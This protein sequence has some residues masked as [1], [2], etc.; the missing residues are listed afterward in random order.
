MKEREKPRRIALQYLVY[1]LVTSNSPL[2][3]TIVHCD[4]I[5]FIAYSKEAHVKLTA[6]EGLGLVEKGTIAR[7][8]WC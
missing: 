2:M 8:L 6:R 4:N 3:M 1:S 7:L 5:N